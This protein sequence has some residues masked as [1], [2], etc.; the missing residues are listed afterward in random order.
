M[1]EKQFERW[2]KRMRFFRKLFHCH[3]LKERSFSFRGMQLPLCA[4][5]T[6]IFLGFIFIGP[7]LSFFTYGN[8][9]LSLSFLLIMFIDGFIQLK[10]I[11]PSTNFRRVTTGLLSGYALFSILLHIIVK[12]IYLCI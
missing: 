9:Y 3:Q 5:C 1:T 10:G 2:Q 4:R 12:A 8:M 6:G 7:I 11:L